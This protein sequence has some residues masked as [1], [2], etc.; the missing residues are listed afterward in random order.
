MRLDVG[1]DFGVIVCFTLIGVLLSRGY[2]K[3]W[4]IVNRRGP[5]SCSSNQ[6]CSR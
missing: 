2:R 1:E 6:S 3:I 5:V 4:T